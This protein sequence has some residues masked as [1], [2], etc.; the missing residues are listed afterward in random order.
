MD[1]WD[2]RFSNLAAEVATWSK[3]KEHQVG[4]VAVSQD[5]L[6]F[7]LG[8]NGFPRDVIETSNRLEQKNKFTVHAEVNAI[9]NAPVRPVGWTLYT[10]RMPCVPCAAVI[11]QAGISRLV[12]PAYT[13]TTSKWFA[14]Q[15][16]A[17]MMLLDAKIRVDLLGTPKLVSHEPH[18]NINFPFAPCVCDCEF[19]RQV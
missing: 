16:E 11:L 5:K 12:C 9:L 13:D 1:K 14:D 8:Y 2:Q 4:A 15:R 7:T 3:D 10:T 19:G 17:E 6:H 18:C